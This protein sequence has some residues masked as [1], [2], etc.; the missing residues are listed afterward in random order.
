MGSRIVEV[1]IVGADGTLTPLDP[2]ATYKVASNDFMRAG[3]DGYTVFAEKATNAYDFGRPL[4][5]VVA[6]YI[7]ANSPVDIVLDG[8]ITRI[9]TP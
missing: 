6:D 3:G 9:D 5:Q 2:A 7:A 1:E 8:R 4:D